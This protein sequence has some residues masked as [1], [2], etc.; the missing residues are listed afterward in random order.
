MARISL[1]PPR[2]LL[3]RFVRWYSRRSFGRELGPA[4]AAGHNP[5]VLKTQ[6]K[7]ERGMSKCDTVAQDLKHLA[8]LKT[9]MTIGCEWCVD[10]GYW[11]SRED[12]VAPEKIDAVGAW[13]DSAAFTSLE[14][15]ALEY[16]EAMTHTPPQVT[17]ELVA[18]LRERLSDAQLVE[19]TAA[20]A[21]ENT[22]GRTNSALGITPEGF[23]E[24]CA[25][26][27]RQVG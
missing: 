23:K 3:N 11:K 14:R 13:R 26:P 10:F 8:M 1:E 2:T 18:A 21:L 22:F 25:L 12:G 5:A 9:A 15:L 27:T 20:I 7:L 6:L 17:D 16:S 24:E 19:L 4:L